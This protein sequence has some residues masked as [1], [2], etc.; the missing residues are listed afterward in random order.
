MNTI[1]GIFSKYLQFTNTEGA[2]GKLIV[3]NCGD[4]SIHLRNYFIVIDNN[5]AT[6]ML[7]DLSTMYPGFAQH[8]NSLWATVQNRGQVLRIP[9]SVSKTS[10]TEEILKE[11]QNVN[12]L[13]RAFGLLKEE[14]PQPATNWDLSQPRIPS[15]LIESMTDAV[16]HK[17]VNEADIFYED[18]HETH[19]NQIFYEEETAN[20]N[21]PSFE[22]ENFYKTS[23][24]KEDVKSSFDNNMDEGDLMQLEKISQDIKKLEE[25]PSLLKELTHSIS[26]LGAQIEAK[27]TN[28]NMDDMLRDMY[29]KIENMSYNNVPV[30]STTEELVTEE[31]IAEC[32][33]L[34]TS[35]NPDILK[36]VMINSIIDLAENGKIEAV[37]DFLYSSVDYMK[38][39]RYIN[40]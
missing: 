32:V 7:H 10:Y 26:T 9:C 21:K 5:K 35:L 28:E 11:H 17:N 3:E 8:L 15:D 40:E 33:Q 24:N 39:R 25:V 29:D 36:E 38:S 6:S 1:Y 22:E 4:Y 34:F 13:L 31:E 30:A 12:N 27:K 20:V 19:S 37:S 2:K 14:Q 23:E 18:E 16:E